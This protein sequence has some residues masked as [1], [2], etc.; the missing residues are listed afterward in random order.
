[1]ERIFEIY[2]PKEGQKELQV[3]RF[4]LVKQENKIEL[5]AVDE[6]GKRIRDGSILCIDSDGILRCF[7]VNPYLGFPLDDK[8]RIEFV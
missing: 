2:E 1:M 3:I 8:G 4:R 7:G 6:N 5:Q